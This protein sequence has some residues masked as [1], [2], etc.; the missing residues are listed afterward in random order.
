MKKG[1]PVM[2][3]PGSRSPQSGFNHGG[4]AFD[5]F[6]QVKIAIGIG[7]EIEFAETT[8]LRFQYRQRL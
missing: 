4:T 7:I 2:D 1:I 3:Y 8:A 6:I 5:L